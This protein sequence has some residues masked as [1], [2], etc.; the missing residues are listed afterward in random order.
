VHVVQG[1]R[2]ARCDEAVYHRSEDLL[3]CEG[4]AELSDG[5]DRVAGEVIEFHLDAE[6]VFVRGGATVLFHPD[7]EKRGSA[8]PAQPGPAG[9]P[10]AETPTRVVA[11]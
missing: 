11:P 3:V 5:D 4:H 8:P 1:T 6:K 2:E 7:S 9:P 10:I